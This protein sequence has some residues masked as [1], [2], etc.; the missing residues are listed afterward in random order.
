LNEI[1]SSSKSSGSKWLLCMAP[2]YVADS[3]RGTSHRVQKLAGEGQA[4]QHLWGVNSNSS[5]RS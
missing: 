1:T 4:G 5:S 2:M 3:E